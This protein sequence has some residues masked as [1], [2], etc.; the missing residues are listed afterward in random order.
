MSRPI[1][2]FVLDRIKGTDEARIRMRVK[3]DGCAKIVA[4]SV[5]YRVNIY[6]WDSEAQRCTPRSFHL[7]SL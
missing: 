5:G 2:A 1:V 4:V 3:W 7:G 6:R